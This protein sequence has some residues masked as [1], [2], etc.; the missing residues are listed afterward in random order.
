MIAVT[1]GLCHDH[2][3]FTL[4]PPTDAVQEL[5]RI[6]TLIEAQKHREERPLRPTQKYENGGFS[7]FS[8]N[9]KK[10]G[11]GLVCT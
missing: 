11:H 1:H 10:R 9:Q 4:Q 6:N 3:I 7:L 8:S 2:H 5:N